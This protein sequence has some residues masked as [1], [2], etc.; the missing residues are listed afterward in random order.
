MQYIIL[1]QQTCWSSFG[2]LTQNKDS[3]A[4]TAPQSKSCGINFTDDTIKVN[5][6]GYQYLQQFINQVHTAR[7]DYYDVFLQNG[8]SEDLV[9]KLKWAISTKVVITDASDGP[10]VTMNTIVVGYLLYIIAG[11]VAIVFLIA[12]FLIQKSCN[13]KRLTNMQQESQQSQKEIEKEAKKKQKKLM[14]KMAKKKQQAQ[15]VVNRPT[16]KN[17]IIAE[18][19]INKVQIMDQQMW[20]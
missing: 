6:G 2:F 15:V 9:K 18:V 10:I 20:K 12:I 19:D 5:V 8:T 13:K 17:N 3:T 16:S 1:S 4:I 11:V 7:T 14:E